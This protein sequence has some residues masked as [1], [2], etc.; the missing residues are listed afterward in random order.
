MAY[1]PRIESKILTSLVTT[2]TRNS[3][4]W[5]VNNPGL[6]GSILGYLAKFAKRYQA[7]VYAF[8]IEG[9][10]IHGVMHFPF[11]N[12]ASFMRDFNSCTAR[13]VKRFVPEYPGG[14]LWGRRYSAEFLP[15]A[16]DIEEY[17]FYV[18]LQPV[19]DGIVERLQDYPGYNFFQDA[20]WG[21]ERHMKVMNWAKF[22]AARRFNKRVRVDTFIETVTLRYERLPGYESL[23]QVEYA[24]LMTKKLEER[25]LRIIEQRRREGKTFLGRDK[26]LTI[27]P[28]SRP[29][30][31]KESSPFN[32]RPR[33]LSINHERR[34]FYRKW[35]F[36]ILNKYK[37]ASLR[38]RQG[39]AK[40]KFPSGTFAPILFRL[41][42]DSEDPSAASIRKKKPPPSH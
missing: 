42:L 30:S 34:A 20:I 2:R 19:Q 3:E 7:Q 27:K 23:S 9:N 8:A 16:E 37:E 35:Y 40:I 17:F 41:I 33:I 11:A 28:G 5:F 21:I 31:T 24:K 1:H 4:L 25:R 36:D 38:Y 15:A 22:N 6:E 39:D 18:A 32:H 26:A 13:A 14:S 10:H 12:R 29:K